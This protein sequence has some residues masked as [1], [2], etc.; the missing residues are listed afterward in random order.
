MAA[1]Q[2]GYRVHDEGR[3]QLD[4][5]AQERGNVWSTSKGTPPSRATPAI[6]SRSDTPKSGLE[7]VSTR[8][9]RVRAVISV[10]RSEV[11]RVKAVVG[12]PEPDELS[13][14]SVVV[15]P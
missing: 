11:G 2:L 4:G 12:H 9:S 3:P 6:A 10:F 15:L 7:M 5:P 1:D 8:I 14:D 13:G